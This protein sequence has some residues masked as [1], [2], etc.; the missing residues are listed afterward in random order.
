MN[1]ENVL[2]LVRPNIASMTPYSTA[3]DE[4]KG[5]IGIC[6][7]ANENPFN[8]GY[9]RY[10]STSLKE[11]VRTM[12]SEKKGIAPQHI[13]LGNGSDEA[14]DLCYRIFCVPGKDNAIGISPSYGM[15]SVCAC[16][17]DVEYRTVSLNDDFSLPVERLL[18]SA[19]K[20]SKL[21]FLCSPNNPTANAFPV[22]ELLD[23]V[24]RFKGIVIVD[25][26][27]ID[28]SSTKSLLP[29]LDEHPNLIL[30]QTFSKAYGL[31]GL[32]IGMAFAAAPIISLFR[33]VKY[34]YNIGTDTLE[35]A[36]K[37]LQKDVEEQRDIIL[38]E[39]TRVSQLLPAFSCV[40]RVYPSEAN[41]LLV[42]VTD[43]QTLYQ[44][45][46]KGGVIVRDRSKVPLCESCL[47]IT[48]GTPEENKR[49]LALFTEFDKQ[50]TENSQTPTI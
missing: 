25:E 12:V 41:F 16:I 36:E 4:Y 10:P 21:L 37:L 40:K 20:N 48:I 50:Q 13:F 18:A 27:Y 39:R 24:C 34:P 5:T 28:F 6:L 31:A 23:I 17:N 15:Y 3:R 38:K 2:S 1:I 8:S 49:M 19:D 35:L 46:L 45:L 44:H 30:L 11:R 33:N 29:L 32:R 43:A 26:A 42:K 14:I 7:D 9:N 47:R 22:E